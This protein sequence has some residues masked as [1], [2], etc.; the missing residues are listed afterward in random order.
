MI[1]G[2]TGSIGSGKS[3]VASILRTINLSVIEADDIILAIFSANQNNYIKEFIFEKL[4]KFPFEDDGSVNRNKLRSLLTPE[5]RKELDD[6]IV[7]YIKAILEEQEIKNGIV[8]FTTSRLFNFKV[9]YVVRVVANNFDTQIERALLRGTPRKDIDSIM[10]LQKEQELNLDPADF[11]INNSS[12]EEH[13][14]GEVLQM[15]GSLK[16]QSERSNFV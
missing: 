11:I 14:R 6:L 12:T 15:I 8:F 10:R 4:G 3:T 13:L 9:D 7:P 16:I 2:I 1:I 5:L